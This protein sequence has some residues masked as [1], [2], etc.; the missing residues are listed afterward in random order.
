MRHILTSQIHEIAMYT[1]MWCI[2]NVYKEAADTQRGWF[3]PQVSV[4]YS[5]QILSAVGKFHALIYS[6]WKLV[7]LLPQK[8]TC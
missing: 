5:Q 1:Q 6:S 3:K 8:L 7:L 2:W 4:P